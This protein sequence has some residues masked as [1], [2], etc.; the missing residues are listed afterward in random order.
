MSLLTIFTAPKPF[1]DEH[2]DRIQNNAIRS[3]LSLGEE[4]QVM[5]VGEE[6]GLAQVATKY[7]VTH[8]PDV[9][10]NEIGTPLVSSIFDLARQNSASPLLAYVNADILLVPDFVQIARRVQSQAREFLLVG[11]RW[12]LEVRQRLDFSGGWDERL[13]A[14]VQSGGQQ[15]PAQGSDYFLFPRA[16]FLDLPDF[17]IG[18][19]GWDN[20]MIYHARRRK[21][22]V[23]DASQDLLV[24]HQEHDYRHLPGGQ[25]HYRLPETQRNI[26]LAGGKRAIFTLH[27]ADH[28]LVGGKLQPIPARG[29]KLLRELET[30]PLVRFGWYGLGEVFFAVFHPKKAWGEWR[31]RLA[32]K[33]NRFFSRPAPQ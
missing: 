6:E 23:V 27:D 15:H 2:I 28:R 16:C 24:V 9:K 22:P 30:Y 33:L 25:A 19:A 11:Q 3:W 12:D 13:K 8:L 7:G 20:W 4:V 5:L 18:R 29:K 31:G 10:R 32:Y 26:N 21:W 14:I 17:A 1:I